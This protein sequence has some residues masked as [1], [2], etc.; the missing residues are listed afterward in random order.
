MRVTWPTESRDAFIAIRNM[1]GELWAVL[2]IEAKLGAGRVFPE[3]DLP[4]VVMAPKLTPD[5]ETGAG[6]WSDD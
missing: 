1:T 5:L 6:T 2:F 3:S 4:G